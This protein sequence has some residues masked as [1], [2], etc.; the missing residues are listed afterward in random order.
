MAR[1]IAQLMTA[2]PAGRSGSLSG[3]IDRW[4][5]T[6]RLAEVSAELVV[7]PPDGFDQHFFNVHGTDS[8]VMVRSCARVRK[9]ADMPSVSTTDIFRHPTMSSPAMAPTDVA[10]AEVE[11]GG[12]PSTR[13]PTRLR[14]H[15]CLLCETLHLLVFL[16]YPYLG[17]I[18]VSRGGQRIFAGSGLLETYRR[19][20][21]PREVLVRM[22]SLLRLA[23]VE[24]SAK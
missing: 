21:L 23:A 1:R 15:Q 2:D 6:I 8:T 16:G 14:T 24:V 5:G 22:A 18:A 13:A 7:P 3:Q 4:T 20:V 9:R 19:S 17:T 12:A 11:P 10:D